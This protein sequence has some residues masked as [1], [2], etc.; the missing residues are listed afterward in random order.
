[1]FANSGIE[2]EDIQPAIT[3]CG[4]PNRITERTIWVEE[5]IVQNDY[6]IGTQKYAT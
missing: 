4:D 2:E 3:S 5:V 1:M 6:A